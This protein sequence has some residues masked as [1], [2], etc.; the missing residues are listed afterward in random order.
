[1]ANLLAFQPDERIAQVMAI[2]TY[3]AAPYLVLKLAGAAYLIWL[4]GRFLLGR[5]AV[6]SLP[7]ELG[8]LSRRRAFWESVTVEVLT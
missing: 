4:G 1:M 2:R 6:V 7:E 8:V 3:E 5:A